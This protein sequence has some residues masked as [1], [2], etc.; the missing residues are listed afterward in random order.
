ML[1]V[2]VGHGLFGLQFRL[3]GRLPLGAEKQN[4]LGVLEKFVRKFEK[5]LF[6]PKHNVKKL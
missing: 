2:Q 5:F 4:H 6:L 3:S 1:S